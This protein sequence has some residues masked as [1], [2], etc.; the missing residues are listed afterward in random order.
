MR[1]PPPTSTDNEAFRSSYFPDPEG[2]LEPTLAPF[3]LFPP[4]STLAPTA[5]PPP[6]GLDPIPDMTTITDPPPLGLDPIITQP[7]VSSSTGNLSTTP[8]TAPSKQG[9]KLKTPT[10]FSG[11]REDLRSFLQEVKLYLRGNYQAYPDDEDQI[12]FVLS[13]MSEGNAKDW[14]EEFVEVAEQTSIQNNTDFTLGT[15]DDLI[16]QITA[17]F[18]PFDGARDAIREMKGMKL[19]NDSIE[20]HVNKFKMLVTK[21]RLAKNDAIAEYFRETL[22]IPLQKEIMRIPEPPK[23]LDDWY[24]WAIQLQNNF[25]IMRNTIGKTKGEDTSSS[26]NKK[27]DSLPPPRRFYFDRSSQKDPNAMD[28]DAMTTEKR[29]ALMKK[30]ACFICEGI[31][32]R[33]SDHKAGGSH[34]DKKGKGKTLQK[35]DI[36]AIH[37]LLQGLSKSDMGELLALTSGKKEEEEEKADDEDF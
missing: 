2:T 14:K 18:S 12:L 34:E 25:L 13:Y 26:S 9:K 24:K 3:G 10:P 23:T 15:F 19:G 21:S 35:S 22:P 17:D 32:H 33:A 5:N 36:K 30:G 16:K 11:K 27:H 31:G 4:E 1:F 29:M 6:F 28:V 8:P 20:E 37:A 7:D